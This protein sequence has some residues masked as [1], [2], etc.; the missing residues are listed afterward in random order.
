[1]IREIEVARSPRDLVAE[2]KLS[3]PS[4]LTNLRLRTAQR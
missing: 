3:H 2:L 4:I 1:V